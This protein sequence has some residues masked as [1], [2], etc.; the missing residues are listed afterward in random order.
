[1]GRAVFPPSCL[2][3]DQTMLEVI[4]KRVSSF[5]RSL[6]ALPHSVPPTLQ[7]AATDP[8]LHWRRLLDIH[9]QVRVS[10]LW[11]H[12]FFLL[13]PG[14]HKVLF[15]PSESAFPIQCNFW[16]LYGGANGDL[17][18]E[19]LC[20][21]PVCCTQS[22]CPCSRPLLTHTSAGDT[23]SKADLAPSLW[24]LLFC[25]RFCLSPQSISGGYGVWF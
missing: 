21:T 17:L 5:K 1:M 24:G 10:L 19:G 15:V 4:K 11:G 22:P 14:A 23:H 12:C 6:Q 18:Q 7:Q 16:W 25:T 8:C 2:T 13:G 20:H 9:G 3:W